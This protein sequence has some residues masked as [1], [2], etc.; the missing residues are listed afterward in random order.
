MRLSFLF[1]LVH[2]TSLDDLR[3]QT[4]TLRLLFVGDIMGHTPQIKSAEVAPGKYNYDPCFKY[5][6]P[7]IERADVAIGN[8]ELTLPGKGPY[9]GY[10]MFRSPDAL[11]DALKQAGFD[12][13]VTANN[14]S[15]DARG[16]GVKNTITTLKDKGF[17]QTGTFASA[18]ERAAFYPLMLYKDG[19]KIA[20]LNYTY[21]TNGVPDEPPTLVNLIDTV[22]IAR[23]LEEAHARK[24]HYIIAVMHWGVEY[25]L[26]ENDEQ[27][28]LARFLVRNGTDLIVGMHPHV[29]QP[30]RKERGTRPDGSPKDVVVVYSLGNFIS[31][32]QQPNTDGGLMFQVDL[33]HR[34]GVPY[35]ETGHYGY[36]PVWRYLHKPTS[37]KP[38]YY[39]L[40]VARLEAN[41]SA[42]PT[43]PASAHQ[44]MARS[45]SSIRKRLTGV[46]EI[47]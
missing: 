23:D 29:V 35:A 17:L 6:K 15:N 42:G 41:P 28:R 8:L 46:A 9:S 25:Q 47:R 31:N 26:T 19:F 1:L 13:L 40:P 14:H 11:A 2:L 33:I 16:L 18:R 34:K 39:T 44:A 7:I 5:V 4:D 10:P 21:G 22:Q 45:A 12:M 24:P 30:I 3:A 37:G 20:I 27:R 32:Q 36:L 43:M 38:I